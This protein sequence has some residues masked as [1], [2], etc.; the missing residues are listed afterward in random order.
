MTFI[1]SRVTLYITFDLML[2]IHWQI[3]IEAIE[4]I[5]TV[6]TL[7]KEKKFHE[8]YCQEIE[9]PHRQVFSSL[10]SY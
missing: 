2:M 7:T 1:W 8:N 4:N 10:S 6:A 5:R 3:A 9:A